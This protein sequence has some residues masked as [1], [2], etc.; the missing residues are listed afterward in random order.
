MSKVFN[1]LSFCVIP[2][3]TDK[4]GIHIIFFLFLEEN[5]CCGYSLE[6][7]HWGASNEYPQQMFSLRNK[8]VISIFQ[9]KKAPYLLL[10]SHRKG[11]KGK[12]LVHVL[13]REESGKSEWQSRNIRNTNISP[14]TWWNSKPVSCKMHALLQNAISFALLYSGFAWTNIQALYNYT[15]IQS[16][17]Y[18]FLMLGL[19]CFARYRNPTIYN[20][21]CLLLDNDVNPRPRYTLPLQTVLIQIGWLLKKPNDLDQHCLLLS[22]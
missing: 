10:W 7:P 8:N 2:I 22:M 16:Y 12:E 13:L 11:R 3:V 14:S 20:L 21:K 18:I 19:L 1:I 6:A 15:K 17:M 9:M 5:I 4:R